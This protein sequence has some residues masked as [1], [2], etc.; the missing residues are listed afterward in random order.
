[1]LRSPM[2]RRK[3]RERLD[4]VRREA[5]AFARQA[6]LLPRDV[7]RPLTPA[8]EHV[9]EGDDVVVFLHGLFASAGVLRPLREHVTRHPGIHGATMS[10]AP[11]TDV[12]GLALRLEGLLAELPPH[13]RVHLVGHSLGG[14]VCRWLATMRPD[15]RIV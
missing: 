13:A 8:P 7:Q 15:P 6:V 9:D 14:I 1:M 5:F 3:L 2:V 4:A 10:Y 11:G 12:E